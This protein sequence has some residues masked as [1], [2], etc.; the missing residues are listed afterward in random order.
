MKAKYGEPLEYG[1]PE[2]KLVLPKSTFYKLFP[3]TFNEHS[4]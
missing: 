3:S 2:A 1:F 4:S